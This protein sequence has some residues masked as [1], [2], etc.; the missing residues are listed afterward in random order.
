MDGTA[1]RELDLPGM[2]AAGADNVEFVVGDVQTLEGVDG[3]DAVVGRLILM[4]WRDP[5]VAL[6]R[7]ASTPPSR[8]RARRP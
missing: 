2:T 6:R 8:W 4:Y 3:F 1:R 5:V 7:A